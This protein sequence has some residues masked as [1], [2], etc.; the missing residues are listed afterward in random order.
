MRAGVLGVVL[1]FGVLGCAKRVLRPPPEAFVDLAGKK[2]S[3]RQWARAEELCRQDGALFK[4]DLESMN[5][6]LAVYLER[7]SAGLTGAWGDEHIAI[8]E[9]SQ[10]L[11][12][13]ALDLESASIDAAEKAGCPF[14]GL[15]QAKELNAMARKRL[16]QAPDLLKVAKAR[17]A[18]ATWKEAHPALLQAARDQRCAAAAKQPVLFHA[19]EDEASR[20]EWLFCDGAKVVATPGNPPAF[21]APPPTV[22]APPPKGGKP[23]KPVKPKLAAPEVYVEAAQAYPAGDVARAPKIP[24][25]VPTKRDDGAAEPE[26]I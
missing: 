12:P 7:T 4:A 25:I 17:A 18:L 2:A 26:A 11:L 21:E 15:A 23:K 5:Q 10:V 19:F 6:L 3:Y 24:R 13:P 20:L 16:E 22:P 8:L 9:D 1:L 14:D